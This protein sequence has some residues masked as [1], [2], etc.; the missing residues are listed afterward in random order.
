MQLELISPT[1]STD[2][3]QTFIYYYNKYNMNI[4]FGQYY[5]SVT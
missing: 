5:L 4:I 3:I 1:D 2:Y